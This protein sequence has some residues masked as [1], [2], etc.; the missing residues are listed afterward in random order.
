MI[1][2]DRRK[3]T[4]LLFVIVFVL[5]AP[6]MGEALFAAAAA[7]TRM[8]MG[9]PQPSGAMMPIWVMTEAK[10]DHKY[11][12]ELQNI[13]ISGGARLTQTLVSGDVD[14]GSSGG[15]VVNAI[16]SGAELVCIAASIP[17]YAFSLYAKPRSR[18]SR[19][20]G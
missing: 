9:Y 17:T 8:R 5:V 14:I 12:F 18:T 2:N 6:V 16:L 4:S 19:A 11:G 7:P 15:A 13:Y 3:W 10:L 20:E 1:L